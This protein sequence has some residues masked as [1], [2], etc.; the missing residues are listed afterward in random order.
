MMLY[1]V[2]WFVLFGWWS[3]ARF[4]SVRNALRIGAV[5]T[6]FIVGKPVYRSTDPRKF[7]RVVRSRLIGGIL[8]AAV[9][10]LLLL[11]IAQIA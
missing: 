6:G 10:L 7:A 5:N 9:A 2:G 1:F 3:G 4:W 11:A 8:W